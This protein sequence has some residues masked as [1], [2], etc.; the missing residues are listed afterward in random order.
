M[1]SLI[2]ETFERSGLSMKRLSVNAGV[3]Y[4]AVH[5]LIRGSRD[6]QLTTASRLCRVLGLE[7]RPVQ[8]RAPRKDK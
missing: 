5:G 4:A 7:L 3:P 2:R 6:P 1:L 8:R